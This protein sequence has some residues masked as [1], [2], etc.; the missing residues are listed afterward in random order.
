MHIFIFRE[1]RS[2]WTIFIF[3]FHEVAQHFCANSNLV[4]SLICSISLTF[5]FLIIYKKN[6]SGQGPLVNGNFI[7]VKKIKRHRKVQSVFGGRVVL[8]PYTSNIGATWT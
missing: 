4:F 1:N 3:Y 2:F 5:S 7:P 6:K 8:H